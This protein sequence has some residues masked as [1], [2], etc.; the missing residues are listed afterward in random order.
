[1]LKPI[2][3]NDVTEYIIEKYNAEVVTGIEN[4]DRCVM[5]CYKKPNNILLKF[6]DKDFYGAPVKF[7]NVNTKVGTI[8]C[9]T[10]GKLKLE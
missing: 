4:D 2:Y 9:D 8:N 7:Y 5:E 10:F 3:L 1:M 6:V